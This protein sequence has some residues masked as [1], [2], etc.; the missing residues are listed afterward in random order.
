MLMLPETFTEQ[1]AGPV[2]LHRAADLLGGHHAEHEGGPVGEG[3]PVGDETAEDEA[4]ALLADPGEI[5]ALC[6]ARCT[7]QTQA[8]R[9]GIH[10]NQ[11]GVRRLRPLRRRLARVARPLL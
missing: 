4:L 3:L 7:A 1:P 5:A 10:G 11:T 8:F 9:R 2:A 6:Q